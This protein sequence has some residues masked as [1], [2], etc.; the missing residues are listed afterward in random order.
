MAK[1]FILNRLQG[2][3]LH[4]HFDREIAARTSVTSPSAWLV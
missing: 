4:P 2:T 3:L 1:D